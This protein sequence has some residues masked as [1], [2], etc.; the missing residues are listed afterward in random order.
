MRWLDGITDSLSQ[1]ETVKGTEA[2]RAAVH[3][4]VTKS[5]TQL[6]HY[7]ATT[8]RCSAVDLETKVYRYRDS[9]G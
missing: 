2:W 5:W 7:T 3:G 4:G 9:E 1:R 6:N 8:K